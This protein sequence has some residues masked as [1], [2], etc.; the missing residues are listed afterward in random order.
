MQHAG[1]G[2]TDSGVRPDAIAVNPKTHMI[3]VMDII[4]GFVYTINSNCIANL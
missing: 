3:C 4:S 2:L 1:T